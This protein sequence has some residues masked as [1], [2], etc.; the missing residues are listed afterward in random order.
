M[1]NTAKCSVKSCPQSM[2]DRT[3][4]FKPKILKTVVG[5]MGVRRQDKRTIKKPHFL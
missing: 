2:V 3:P 4:N 1:S 5:K